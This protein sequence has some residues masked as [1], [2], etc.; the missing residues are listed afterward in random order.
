LVRLSASPVVNAT[1]GGG[2]AG[3]FVVEERLGG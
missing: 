2:E 3:P 1:S